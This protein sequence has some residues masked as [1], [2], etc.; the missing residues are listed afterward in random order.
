MDELLQVGIIASPHGVKGEAKVFPTTDDAKRFKKL[1]SVILDQGANKVTLDVLQVKFSGKFVILKFGGIESID[2][3]AKYKGKGLFVD[4]EHAVR[5][6]KDEYFIADLI[7]ITVHTENGDMFGTISNVIETGANDV[8]VIDTGEHGE[9]LVPAIRQC[10]LNV[11]I[12][13]RRMVI[14]LMKGLV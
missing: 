2:D 5:L 13:N 14:R 7:G 8:Y 12:P 10:I 4:R 3:I 6:E 11:D 9:V 1:K